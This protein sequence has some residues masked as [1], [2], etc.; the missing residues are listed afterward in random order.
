MGSGLDPDTS[1]GTISI[2]KTPPEPSKRGSVRALEWLN[3]FVAD[4]QTGIGPFLAAYLAA[5]GWAPERLGMLLTVGGLMPIALQ[6]PA[7]GLVDG[8]RNRRGLLAAAVSLIAGGAVLLGWRATLP[9]VVTAQVVLACAVVFVA[10]LL[11][12]IA[13]GIVGP[14]GFDRQ[15]GRNQAFGAAGNVVTA[16][17]MAGVSYWIGMRWIFFCTALLTIPTLACLSRVRAK[18]IDARMARGAKASTVDDGETR[19][20]GI[21]RVLLQDRVLVIFFL[22]AALFHLSNAA[23]LPELGEMLAHGRARVAGPLMSACVIVTQLVISLTAAGTGRLA[24]TLGRRPLLL[25][26]FAML[27]VRGCLYTVVRGSAALIAVQVLDGIA[28]VVFGVV[29]VLVIADRTRGTGRFNLAQGALACFVGIGASLS[30][31]Y[32]GFLI[33]R[34]SYNASFLGL[35]GVGL[36]AFCVLLLLFPETRVE[37][38][39]DV[40]AA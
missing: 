15:L 2:K 33:Q 29:S 3:F 27:V 23:M 11:G 30:T 21:F 19:S 20:A 24:S 26:G 32:G 25:T 10:P 7:G 28:N 37:D 13:L 9:V 36:V 38:T 35:A 31:T 5:S 12:A 8:A 4:V 39:R 6:I 17:L 16:L 40:R 18:D 1:R 34:F 14:G 22:C